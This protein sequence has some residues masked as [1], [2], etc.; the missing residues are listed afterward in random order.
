MLHA[1]ASNAVQERVGS[2]GPLNCDR[3]LQLL[4]WGTLAEWWM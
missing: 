4:H 3:L 2:G 1:M